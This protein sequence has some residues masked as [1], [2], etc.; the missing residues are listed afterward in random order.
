[1]ALKR[2]TLIV[3]ITALALAAGIGGG[4]WL[5][6]TQSFP[7]T[8]TESEFNKLKD[9]EME[10]MDTKVFLDEDLEK[11]YFEKRQQKGEYVYP[12][13]DN[14][15]ILVSLGPVKNEKTFLMVNGVKERNGKL[16]IGYD[17]LVLKNPPSIKFEDDI[18]SALIRVKGKYDS[19]TFVAVKDKK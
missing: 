15:Y 8:M 16:I 7:D 14:T 1:M 17:T 9:K 4:W 19:V 10:I 5:Y 12:D 13:G 18:R 11:W 6:E 3:G 2:K